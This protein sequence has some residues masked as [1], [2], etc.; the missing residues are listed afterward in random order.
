MSKNCFKKF[1]AHILRIF[2]GFIIN[3]RLL[4]FGFLFFCIWRNK[5]QRLIILQTSIGLSLSFSFLYFER[6]EA[7]LSLSSLFRQPTMG[8]FIKWPNKMWGLVCEGPLRRDVPL[9]TYL[10]ICWWKIRNANMVLVGAFLKIQLLKTQKIVKNVFNIQIF[11]DL[12]RIL[13]MWIYLF[14]LSSCF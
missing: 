1:F 5:Y 2:L 12:F 8:F 6:T 14:F 10:A 3:L 13:K 7:K 4:Y 11:F 9:H